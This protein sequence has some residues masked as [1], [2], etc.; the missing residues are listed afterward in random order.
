MFPATGDG[1]DQGQQASCRRHCPG[2]V[3][4]AAVAVAFAE[5]QCADKHNGQSVEPSPAIAA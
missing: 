3:E 1:V 2:D 5:H 4:S